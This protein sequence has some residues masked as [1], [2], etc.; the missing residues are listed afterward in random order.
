MQVLTKLS[1]RSGLVRQYHGVSRRPVVVGGLIVFA[2]SRQGETGHC[3]R[4][5]SAIGL[6]AAISGGLLFR[7]SRQDLS[8]FL[9]ALL[10]S[11]VFL[12]P[13][14]QPLEEPERV[15]RGLVKRHLVEILAALLS[16]CAYPFV[17]P[18]IAEYLFLL[19]SLG[20]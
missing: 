3:S 6:G 2:P 13:G 11:L 17:N 14:W 8:G 7:G 4:S 15:L 1:R 5:S 9:Q 10:F 18:L 20:C 12:P 19:I 16:K